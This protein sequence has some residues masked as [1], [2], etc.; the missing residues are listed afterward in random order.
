MLFTLKHLKQRHQTNNWYSINKY[1]SVCNITTATFFST[2]NYFIK[3]PIFSQC[4][5]SFSQFPPLPSS[6]M[7]CISLSQICI[8]HVDVCLNS[9]YPQKNSTLIWI[10]NYL[11]SGQVHFSSHNNIPSI[12]EDG[13]KE[14]GIK[15]DG[16]KC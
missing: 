12:Q 16:I 2:N 7:Q 10:Q 11:Q 13:I 1:D 8:R 9:A 15:E 3:A 5:P 4:G 14:D 6:L